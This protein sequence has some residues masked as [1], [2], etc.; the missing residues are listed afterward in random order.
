MKYLQATMHLGADW[1]DRVWL[2][3]LEGPV[4]PHFVGYLG[5]GLSWPADLGEE[6]NWWITEAAEMEDAWNDS[7]RY[8]R[9]YHA[10]AMDAWNRSRM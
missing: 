9:D 6:P 5:E 1:L 10:A 8:A 3:R 2:W 4:G 7:L